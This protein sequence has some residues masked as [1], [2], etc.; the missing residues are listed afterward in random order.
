MNEIQSG[1]GEEYVLLKWEEENG[2]TASRH[3]KLEKIFNIEYRYLWGEW[4]FHK[5][6]EDCHDI[7]TK[8]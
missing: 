7:V 5:V 4:L 1:D 3:R 8:P 6:L 2:V